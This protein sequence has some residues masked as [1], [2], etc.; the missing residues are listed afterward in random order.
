MVSSTVPE[1]EAAVVRIT[2]GGPRPGQPPALR[3]EHVRTAVDGRYAGQFQDMY[4]GSCAVVPYAADSSLTGSLL[5]R[6]WA[7]ADA[8]R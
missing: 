4:P 6:M 5:V 7:L 8:G 2:R 1:F 3:Y